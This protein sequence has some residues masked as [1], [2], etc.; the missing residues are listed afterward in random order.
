MNQEPTFAEEIDQVLDMMASL[1]PGMDPNTFTYTRSTMLLG[2]FLAARRMSL[3]PASARA[4][5]RELEAL[6]IE[7]AIPG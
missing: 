5:R 3:S 1:D 6:S 4:L 2:A 7:I